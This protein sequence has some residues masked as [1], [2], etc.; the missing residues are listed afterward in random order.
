M[1]T[2]RDG[3]PAAVPEIGFDPEA[4]L[5][6]DSR[7][8]LDPTFLGTLHAEL[9]R[10]LAPEETIATLL[11]MGFLHGLQDAT[12]ALAATAGA[13]PGVRGVPMALPLRMPC[14]SR[15]VR[16]A[17]GAIW[18]EGA[19]PDHHEAAAHRSALGAGA[20]AE[21]VCYLSAGYTSGWLTGAFD[22]DLLAVETSC[23]ATGSGACRF[24]AREVSDW[25]TRGDPVAA[26]CLAALPFSAFRSLVRERF[27]RTQQRVL[28][29]ELSDPGRMD[30]RA[31]AV[32]IWGPVMVLPYAGPNETLQALE[33]LARDPGATAVS[34]IVVDLGGAIIDDAFGALALE[35]LVQTAEA[36]GAEVLFVDP[37]PLSERVLADLDHPPLLIEKD[38]EPTVALAFQIARSQRRLT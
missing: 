18:V 19:W 7:V 21:T 9:A 27:A 35:Q 4:V 8:L 32:H 25:S 16:E 22:A 2:P 6:R 37:S 23:S 33:L 29:E 15:E 13:R 14:C 3:A 26:R 31:A 24:V 12:R 5:E 10:E 1:T 30:R 34:V 20:G 17:P 11:Q 38:L 28:P 36:W